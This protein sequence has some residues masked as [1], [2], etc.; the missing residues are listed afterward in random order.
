MTLDPGLY[1][2]ATPIGN[3][4]D[5][6]YRAVETLKGADLILCEDTRHTAKLC[7]AYGVRTRRL[8]YHEHNEAEALPGVL[9]RLEDGARIALVSDAGTPLLSDPGFRLV[10]AARARGLPVFAVPGP[11]AAVAAL[12]VAGVATDRFVFAGFPPPKSGAR[13]TALGALAGVDATLV[14]YESP[15][16]LAASL[17][18]MA[19]VFGAR[20]AAV[21]RELTKLHETLESGP[22][23]ALAARFAE[24]PAR[25]EIVVLVAPPASR[26]QAGDADIDA[27]LVDALASLSIRDAAQAAADALG[28][29]RK[30]A[31]ARA[32]ALKKPAP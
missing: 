19:E 10:A 5:I 11:C 30:D 31:Y 12:S 15:Q 14:F 8:A 7:A 18:D 25:G 6:T 17:A 4:G 9:G 26:P 16:R 23:A 20:E 13:R 29:A 3:L 1:V 21:A 28:I 32:V 27:F 22:L 2:T 24:T